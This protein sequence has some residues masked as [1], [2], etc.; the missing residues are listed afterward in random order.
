MGQV[1]PFVDIWFY[2]TRAKLRVK[3]VC[4]S[5]KMEQDHFCLQSAIQGDK[6]GIPEG[7]G[8][9]NIGNKLWLGRSLIPWGG[10]GN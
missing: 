2:E 7:G 9:G 6:S 4:V 10:E 3:L 8:E 5:T 1:I